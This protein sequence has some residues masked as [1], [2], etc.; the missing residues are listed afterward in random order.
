MEIDENI[1]IQLDKGN[2]SLKFNDY[3]TPLKI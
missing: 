2:K 3:F 1:E